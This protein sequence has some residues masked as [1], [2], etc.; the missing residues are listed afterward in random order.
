MVR[1][2]S[3]HYNAIVRIATA[4]KHLHWEL[5]QMGMGYY[6]GYFSQEQELSHTRSSPGES[7]PKGIADLQPKETGIGCVQLYDCVSSWL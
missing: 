3:L 2:Q 5:N 4:A 7:S 6:L 1:D